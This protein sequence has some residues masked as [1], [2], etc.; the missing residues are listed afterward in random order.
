MKKTTKFLSL[1]VALFAGL[2][3]TAQAA[4]GFKIGTDLVSSYVWRGSAY[5]DSPALQPALSSTFPDRGLGLG[6][7]G[8]VWYNW[9][10]PLSGN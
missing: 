7:W 2:S 5:G 3:G 4:D 8:F 6:A 9:H 10:T 1:A